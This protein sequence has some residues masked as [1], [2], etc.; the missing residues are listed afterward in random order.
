MASA[1]PNVLRIPA[2]NIPSSHAHFHIL[3]SWIVGGSSLLTLLVLSLEVLLLVA[4][5]GVMK[6]HWRSKSGA[7]GFGSLEATDFWIGFLFSVLSVG[8]D[9]CLLLLGFGRFVS[10]G[11]QN[12]IWSRTTRSIVP[13][14]I[15]MPDRFSM[16]V[17]SSTMRLEFGSAVLC[18]FV[19]YLGQIQSGCRQH[20]P[21]SE[22]C[23]SIFSWREKRGMWW[24]ARFL[25]LV[26]VEG[27]QSVIAQKENRDFGLSV[28]D[29]AITLPLFST[30]LLTT[31]RTK[32][33]LK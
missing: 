14:G 17:P 27:V 24:N 4:A 9:C 12:E 11:S 28:G 19:V 3:P 13:T 21:D 30:S 29:I 33:P 7:L 6:T 32:L 18:E 15:N 5:F 8:V 2:G 16:I 20:Q 26:L 1:F 10:T 22:L 31:L 25:S 23:C